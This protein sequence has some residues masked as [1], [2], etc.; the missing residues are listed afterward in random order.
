MRRA[1]RPQLALFAAASV[2]VTLYLCSQELPQPV[3]PPRGSAAARPP[4]VTVLVW[5]QPFGVAGNTR[6]C[7]AVHNV[8]D[9]RITSDRDQYRLSQAV[10]MHHRDIDLSELPEG[11]PPSQRWIWMNFESPSHTA[12]VERLDGMFNWT[13]TYKLE[14][15]IFIPYGYFYR[16]EKGVARLVLPS[17]TK[18]VAWVI[19]NWNEDHRRVQYYHRLS[20]HL[21]IEVYGQHGMDL[22]NNSVVATVSQYKFYLAFENSQHIDYITEKVWRNAFLSSAVPVVLGPTRAN[23]EI[24]LP[25]D[26]FIHVD[27]FP[28]PRKL[29]RYLLFLDKHSRRYREYFDWKKRYRVHVTAFWDEHYCKVCKAVRSA[30]DQHKTISHLADWFHR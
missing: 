10:V 21:D 1:L 26:S 4:P 18:L 30:G 29:A 23:Y 24:F 27:D 28:T 8:A 7:E 19:S 22:K 17:K 6:D 12:N 5:W 16:Q 20:S 2:L 9:C 15:D 14:S 25:P 3:P 13:M 11:R